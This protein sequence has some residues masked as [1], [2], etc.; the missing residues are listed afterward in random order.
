A[1]RRINEVQIEVMLFKAFKLLHELA[2]SRPV[3]DNSYPSLAAS[4]GCEQT[5]TQTRQSSTNAV[6]ILR[7]DYIHHTRLVSLSS[8]DA[9]ERNR[10]RFR[11]EEH[12]RHR[13]YTC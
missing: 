5:V 6:T 3:A 2:H 11:S 8:V 12:I 4:N 1:I 10:R 7:V 9:G 13:I